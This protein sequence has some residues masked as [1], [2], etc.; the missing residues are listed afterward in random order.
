MN[1]GSSATRVSLSVHSQS[2]GNNFRDGSVVPA[3]TPA[4]ITAYCDALWEELVTKGNW[5]HDYAMELIKIALKQ[6]MTQ[7]REK[8]YSL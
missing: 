8:G 2:T 3:M 7:V 4:Q 6:K 5:G 1:I